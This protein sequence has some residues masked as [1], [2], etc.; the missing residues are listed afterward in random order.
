MLKQDTTESGD[1]PA[2]QIR[3]RREEFAR[4]ISALEARRQE[5]ARYLEGTVAV[6]DT[7]RELQVDVSAEEVMQQIEAQRAGNAVE[8]EPR[9]VWDPD[10]IADFKLVAGI[11]LVPLLAVFLCST[12]LPLPWSPRRSAPARRLCGCRPRW[13]RRAQ[14][15]GR[16]MTA[17]STPVRS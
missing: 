16:W 15:R 9:R 6:E 3:V 12:R 11:V 5:E 8:E 13:C 4:A 14:S 17:A 10:K 1:P 7:L 2:A